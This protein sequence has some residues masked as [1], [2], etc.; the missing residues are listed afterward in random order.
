MATE[1][2]LALYDESV[3]IDA[4]N[5]LPE[6]SEDYIQ[7]LLEAGVTA[8]DATL[9]SQA[10]FP[11]TFLQATE[12]LQILERVV[13][14]NGDKAAIALTARDIENCKKEGKV[15]I[16]A[17]SQD[18]SIIEANVDNVDSLFRLGYRVIQITNSTRNLIGDGCLE[19]VDAGLSK[20]GIAVIERMNELGMVIDLSHVGPKTTMEAIEFSKAPVCFTH[21]NAMALCDHLRNKSD[22]ALKA[23]A[24]K[25][26]VIGLNVISSYSRTRPGVEPDIEDYYN[27]MDYVVDL[28]GAD[29]VGIGT[30]ISPDWAP[31]EIAKFFEAYPELTGTDAHLPG[32]DTVIYFKDLTQGL[33][34][35][36]YSQENVRKILGDNWLRYF[37]TVWGA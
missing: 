20:F 2:G 19:R 18:G 36:G 21:A 8:V 1:S 35:R 32:L 12:R 5:C 15:A 10:P 30:D 31:E 28:V 34:D 29:H 24:E 14:K 3:V 11:P 6:L 27:M 26:G 9:P 23:V 25:G 17:G 4:L 37:R 7:T 22:E 16:I 33:L 13:N